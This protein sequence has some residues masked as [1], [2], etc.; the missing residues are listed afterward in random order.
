LNGN[1]DV[2]R[3]YVLNSKIVLVQTVFNSGERLGCWVK[4][5]KAVT[6]AKSLGFEQ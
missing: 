5:T 6:E 2:G 3:S 1:I 4:K